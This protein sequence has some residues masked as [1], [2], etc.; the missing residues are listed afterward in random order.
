RRGDRSMLCDIRDKQPDV[1]G[2]LLYLID[3][4]RFLTD[5]TEVSKFPRVDVVDPHPKPANGCDLFAFFNVPQFFDDQISRHP[6]DFGSLLK[7]NWAAAVATHEWGIGFDTHR[8]NSEE[9]ALHCGHHAIA[10]AVSK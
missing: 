8:T 6:N 4:R 10:F 9:H 7:D 3:E 5:G 2:A 1:F